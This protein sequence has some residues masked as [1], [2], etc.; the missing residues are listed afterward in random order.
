[1]KFFNFLIE[2]DLFVILEEHEF[3]TVQFGDLIPE[4]H[5]TNKLGNLT[6]WH[7]QSWLFYAI[8]K[9]DL[10]IQYKYIFYVQTNLFW[11]DWTNLVRVPLRMIIMP[12]WYL[13]FGFA[14]SP[15]YYRIGNWAGSRPTPIW[16]GLCRPI[17]VG[18]RR[19]WTE[20]V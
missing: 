14:F 8:I 15:F 2:N 9:L 20:L 4:E 13:I 18:L 10:C 11:S 16:F 5:A 1:M 7:S 3:R 19:T 17:E 6:N 12:W